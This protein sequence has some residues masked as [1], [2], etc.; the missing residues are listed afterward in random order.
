MNPIFNTLQIIGT[1]KISAT[2]MW[3]SQIWLSE[4]LKASK[5]VGICVSHTLDL[6]VCM[7]H[8]HYFSYQRTTYNFWR[9]KKKR[10]QA[11]FNTYLRRVATYN[12]RSTECMLSRK[13]S[14]N[15]KNETSLISRSRTRRGK[16]D[17]T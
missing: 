5:F 6:N 15:W 11:K 10:K 16:R 8:K 4:M 2:P 17:N 9:K 14:K 12:Q 7:Y 13:I 3:Q 1:S